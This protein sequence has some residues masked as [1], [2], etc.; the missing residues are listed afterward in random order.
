MIRSLPKPLSTLPLAIA[1]LASLGCGADGG[2]QATDQGDALRPGD[3][4]TS[5]V[6]ET[7]AP[8]GDT[9]SSQDIAVDA[10][11]SADT[12]GPPPDTVDPPQLPATCWPPGDT[13]CDPRDGHGCE[14][15]EGETCDLALGDAG[16]PV[17][18]CFPGP[19]IA[20]LG[21]SCDVQTGPFC[22]VGMTC[23]PSRQCRSFCCADAECPTGEECARFRASTSL[24]V[25]LPEGPACRGPGGF[26]ASPAD[27]CSG[28]CHIDHCH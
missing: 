9:A 7:S 12:A 16:Q 13:L 18:A 1:L 26:C 10:S 27:C 19:N 14:L 11:D 6:A 3:T 15:A 2:G 21:A 28:V 23:D 5:D 24:G 17:V 25:C 22:A 4:V 20:G 8:G